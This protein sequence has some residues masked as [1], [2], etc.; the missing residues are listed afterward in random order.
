[1]PRLRVSSRASRAFL[2]S[3]LSILLVLTTIAPVLGQPVSSTLIQQ[4]IQSACGFLE[5]LYRPDLGLL[6]TTATS[7]PNIFYIASDN[8]LAQKALMH[9]GATG[10]TFGVNITRSVAVCCGDGDD[11]MHESL[12]GSRIPLPIRSAMTYSIANSTAGKFWDSIGTGMGAYAVLWEVHNST[13]ILADCAYGDV[14]VYT[15]LE[16]KHEGNNTGASHEMECLNVMSDGT[17]IV[18]E[19]YK[20]GTAG[21]HGVYQTFKLALYYLAVHNITGSYYTYPRELDPLL[22]MQGPD[23]GFHTGYDKSG[24]Y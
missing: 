6:K 8:L 11:L 19:A 3:S 14:A 5:N 12:L 20:D 24:T 2:V 16:L 23:G 18:D 7:S 21:E 13:G 17:G 15:A 22:R 9:C 10:A 1:M 4:R